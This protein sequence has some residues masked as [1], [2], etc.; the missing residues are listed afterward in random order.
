MVFGLGQ[1]AAQQAVRALAGYSVYTERV[2]KTKVERADPLAA[3]CEAGNV[4]VVKGPW[5][6]DYLNELC[7]FPGGD[8]DDQVDASSGAFHKLAFSQ[9][10]VHKP[11]PGLNR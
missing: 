7:S 2:T 1:E 3:Q 6:S 4:K 11:A 10:R 5:N 9:T 8:H